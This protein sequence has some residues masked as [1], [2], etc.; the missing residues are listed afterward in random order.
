[1]PNVAQL[2]PSKYLAAIDLNGND[3]DVKIQS[4]TP[5]EEVGQKKDKKPIVYFEG[6]TKGLVLNKTNAK[7]IVKLYGNE[8]DNWIGKTITLYPS[9]CDYGDETVPCIRV[10]PEAP[11]GKSS[12]DLNDEDRELLEELKK[13]KAAKRAQLSAN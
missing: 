3:H 7:R 8:T 2:F 5:S 13:A 6:I 4:L 1:M 12:P 10:R 9:E 11:A